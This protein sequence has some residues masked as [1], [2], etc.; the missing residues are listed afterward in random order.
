MR[1]LTVNNQ[2]YAV[3]IL[4]QD[5]ALPYLFMLHG[6]MGDQRVFSHLMDG[7]SKFCNPI[8]IDLLG[9]GRTDKPDS[10]QRYRDQNQ[11]A[12]LHSLIQKLNHEPL[13]LHGYSMGGRL[14]LQL[15]S[16]YTHLFE[17]LILES[18]TCGIIDPQKRKERQ[19]IDTQRAES[20]TNNFD[21]FL[22]D[23]KN[24]DLFTSPLPP[25]QSL[26]QKY[27][28]IQSE[29]SSSALA[30]SLKGFGTGTMTPVCDDLPNLTLPTLLIAGSADKKYQRINQNLSEQLPNATFSSIKAGHRVHLDNPSVFIDR[31]N[32]FL[33]K[34]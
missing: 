17:G 9:F 31:I 20:I 26:I 27:H 29:Q 33:N 12:D 30:A 23:W 4:Q 25:D 1:Y 14:A 13:Y 34:V 19:N 5:N 7:L 11:V 15:A 6:F 28:Q 3:S 2:Q 32:D 24:I 22:S 21:A 18:T 10:P 16:Q 8:T